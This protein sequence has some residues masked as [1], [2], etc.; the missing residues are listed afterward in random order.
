[1]PPQASIVK[2]M[3]FEWK[4]SQAVCGRTTPPGDEAEDDEAR[5]IL[6][7]QGR[8]PDSRARLL[9]LGSSPGT[10]QLTVQVADVV[11]DVPA[12]LG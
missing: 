12:V 6:K 7:R 8:T 1:M 9:W 4:A 3:K 5:Q 11:D 10:S 2:K